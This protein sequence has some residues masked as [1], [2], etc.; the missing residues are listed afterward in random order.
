MSWALVG[1][2]GVGALLAGP[3]AR[4]QGIG[5]SHRFGIGAALGYP[6]NG[7]SMNYFLERNMSLQID[8][9]LRLYSYGGYSGGLVGARVDLLFYPATLATGRVA[10]LK[11]Y[12][13]PGANFALGLG[14]FRGFFLAAEAAVGLTVQFQRAPV[15]IAFEL[16]PI[17]AILSSG[18][19]DVGVGIGGALH[20]RYYF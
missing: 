6:F 18:G 4:A 3:E 20:V 11:F 2:L 14:N 19:V 8:P 15:D 13:G 9:A 7:L 12:V 5:A 17:L 1:A 16:V 10:Q